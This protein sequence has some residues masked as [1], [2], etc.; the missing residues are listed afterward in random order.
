MCQVKANTCTAARNSPVNIFLAFSKLNLRLSL[1]DFSRRSN[2][3]GTAEQEPQKELGNKRFA[4]RIVENAASSSSSQSISMRIFSSKIAHQWQKKGG[5]VLAARKSN[6]GVL[7][8]PSLCLLAWRE[9][10]QSE[11]ENFFAKM[12]GCVNQSRSEVETKKVY[13]SNLARPHTSKSGQSQFCCPC[14]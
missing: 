11:E 3:G 13:V 8:G 6:I 2:E 14:F 7:N 10:K 9:T 12:D 4:E 1:A 5:T